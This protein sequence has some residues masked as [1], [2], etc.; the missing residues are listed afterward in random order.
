[1][2]A[3]AAAKASADSSAAEL[4]ALQLKLTAVQR[5]AEMAAQKLKRADERHSTQLAAAEKAT[6][7]ALTQQ[8]AQLQEAH[9]VKHARTVTKAVIVELVIPAP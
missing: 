5:S 3:V 8:A 6:G 1:M 4:R 7:E 2:A 9:Q